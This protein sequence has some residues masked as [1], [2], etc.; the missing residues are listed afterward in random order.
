MRRT[1]GLMTRD[2]PFV[3]SYL[4]RLVLTSKF[5]SLFW[6]S[7]LYFLVKR[8]FKILVLCMKLSFFCYLLIGFGLDRPAYVLGFHMKSSY[9]NFH[10]VVRCIPICFARGKRGC[11]PLTTQGL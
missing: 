5:V 6:T 11:R 8:D 3:S 4:G 9:S 7:V 10:G 1:D 2:D